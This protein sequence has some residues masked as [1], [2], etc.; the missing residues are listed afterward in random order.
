[1]S[2]SAVCFKL[3]VSKYPSSVR[4]LSEPV[5]AAIDSPSPVAVIFFE[6]S[7]NERHQICLAEAAI[8]VKSC[9]SE[10]GS[11]KLFD[12]Y[13]FQGKNH[14]FNFAPI[15]RAL[16]FKRIPPARVRTC[17]SCNFPSDDKI[18]VSKRPKFF[19]TLSIAKPLPYFPVTSH[20]SLPVVARLKAIIVI[21]KPATTPA[22][23]ITVT[24]IIKEA[25]ANAA[26]NR[27]VAVRAA[28]IAAL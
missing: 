22:I 24:F 28:A 9:F 6:A 25:I 21:V 2:R 7:V 3:A 19:I 4:L 23:T 5:N 11:N 17:W 12:R 1:M 10:E 13:C 26:M 20:R 8:Q 18:K 14:H 16:D 27:A 15:E